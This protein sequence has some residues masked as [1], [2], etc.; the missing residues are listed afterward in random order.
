MEHPPFQS[1]RAGQSLDSAPRD[2]LR[3]PARQTMQGG[4]PPLLP[5]SAPDVLG[6]DRLAAR[7]RLAGTS[8]LDTVWTALHEAAR[9]VAVLAG[10]PPEPL[11]PDV[12]NFPA[13]MRATGGWRADQA[14]DGIEDLAAVLQPGLRALIAAQGRATPEALRQAAQALWQEFEAARATLLDLIPP[15]NLRPQR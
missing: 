3:E 11:R 5:G 9:A 10:R 1:F 6:A 8:P 12:R 2:P 7:A 15:L 4:R 13:I 14:R